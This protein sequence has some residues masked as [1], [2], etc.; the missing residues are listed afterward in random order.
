MTDCRTDSR[1]VFSLTAC[2]LLSVCAASS[3]V[4]C[5]EAEIAN[6]Q[7]PV[8]STAWPEADALFH[9]DPRWL[10]GDD[11]YSIDL[12]GRR[13]AWFF[14]DSFVAPTISG[15]RRAS[16]MV[17]NSV[18]IQT[19]YDPTHAKFRTYW[20]VTDGK[21][22]SFFPD[23]GINYFWPGGSLLIDGKLLV[24]F[25][26]AHTKDPNSAMGFDTD[27]WTAVL[28][29]NPEA[30]PDNWQLRQ[31]DA[32]QNDFGV[33]VGSASLVRDGE[34]LVAFSVGGESHDVYLVR[35]P[36]AGAA[37]GNFER[38]EWWAGAERGWVAQRSLTALPTPIMRQGQTEFTVDF[39]RQLDCFLQF[40]F[41]GFPL[42]AVGFRTADSLTGPWSSLTPCYRP[43]E[44]DPA[45]SGLMLYAAKAHPEQAAQGLAL[46]YASNT[47]DFAQLLD[48]PG[49]YYPHFFRVE[50]GRSAK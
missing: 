33:L 38:P 24:F 2:A 39:S 14:G 35:W 29:D 48:S 36:L 4:W 23:D 49:I 40:Q 7:L 43:E 44:L 18:G 15:Q 13:V 17:H 32:P 41:E 31:L 3:I 8:T 34:H 9:R 16:T 10:G 20:R 19:G 26:R 45:Q 25:M 11:A 42:T 50:W 5:D 22:T 21:P 27:G 6:C 1:R 12:G 47:F 46:T 30:D 37:A 28:I